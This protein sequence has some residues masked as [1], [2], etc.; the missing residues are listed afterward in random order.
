MELKLIK[1]DQVQ[2]DSIL[3]GLVGLE[4]VSELIS[5]NLGPTGSGNVAS[6]GPH[7]RLMK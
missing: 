4:L 6:S 1:P 7:S 3:L 5:A 2:Q